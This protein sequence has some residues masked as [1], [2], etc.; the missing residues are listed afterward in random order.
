[1]AYVVFD[2]LWMLM[3]M[4]EDDWSFASVVM[5]W[6][7]LTSRSKAGLRQPQLIGQYV[8]R[9]ETAS[10]TPSILIDSSFGIVMVDCKRACKDNART[11]VLRHKIIK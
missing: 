5:T 10:R 8:A 4:D 9:Q 11:T 3:Q 6:C 2:A 7:W 1:V